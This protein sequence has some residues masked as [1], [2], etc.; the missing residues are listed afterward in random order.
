MSTGRSWSSQPHRTVARMATRRA[1]L[2]QRRAAMGYTQESFAVHLGVERSTVARWERGVATPQPWSEPDIAKAL[3][4]SVDALVE[5]LA[6]D[7]GGLAIAPFALQHCAGPA[8][9]ARTRTVSKEFQV[10]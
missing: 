3:K 6:T 8:F 1:S 2:A 5:L 7:S 10:A 9:V 4:I